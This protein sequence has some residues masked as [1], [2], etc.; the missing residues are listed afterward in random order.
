MAGVE[1]AAAEPCLPFFLEWAPGTPFPG[2][3]PVDHPGGLRRWRGLRVA[4][5]PDRI[6]QWTG[7]GVDV[8]LRP[9]AP[10]VLAAVLDGDGGELVIDGE[11]LD[12]PSS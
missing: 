2:G 9:G 12:K 8:D 4:G 5:D 3:L 7:G 10:A 11:V 1:E 6:E